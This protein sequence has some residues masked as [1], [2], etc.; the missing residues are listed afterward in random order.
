MD[1]M[2]IFLNY[3]VFLSLMDVLILAN[4]AD[5]GSSLFVMYLLRDLQFTRVK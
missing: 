4:S 2:Y 1:V 5:S 3:D